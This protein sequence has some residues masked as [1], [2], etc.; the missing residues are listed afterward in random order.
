MADEFSISVSGASAINARLDAWLAEKTKR[1]DE[2]VQG[3]GINCQ[4]GAKQRAPVD[5]G[6]FRAGYTY[7]KTGPCQCRVYNT[8]FYG[9]F[10][11][12]GTSRMRA[13]PSLFPA[14]VDAR[15]KLLQELRDIYRS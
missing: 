15:T 7:E 6:R 11:E 4:S 14:Y 3:A 12:L 5:T 2:A 10:L 9:I 8:V 13:R 1:T